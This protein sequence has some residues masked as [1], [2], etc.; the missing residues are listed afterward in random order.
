MQDLRPGD[1]RDAAPPLIEQVLH[2]E[3]AAAHVIGRDG[4]EPGPWRRAVDEH[5]RD[6]AFAEPDEVVDVLADGR[7]EH[8]PHSLLREQVEVRRLSFL[9]LAA[10][11]HEHREAVA[12]CLVFRTARELCVERVRGVEHDQSDGEAAP[13]AQLAGGVVAHVPEFGHSGAHALDCAVGHDIRPV[14]HVR[15]RAERYSGVRCN[16]ADADGHRAPSPVR[17]DS[18]TPSDGAARRI[19]MSTRTRPTRCAN[20]PLTACPPQ[21]PSRLPRLRPVDGSFES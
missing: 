11:A 17:A 21:T 15:H 3:V 7:D 16:V 4:G 18:V 20:A 10:V 5:H 2:G 13:C 9:L 12:R 6:A 1:V 19:A 8:A 14:Q